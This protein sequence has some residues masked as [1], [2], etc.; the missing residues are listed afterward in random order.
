[1][2][3]ISLLI[4]PASSLCNMRCKYCF[5]EDEAEN[6]DV[7]SHG[8]MSY[9]VM[10]KMLDHIFDYFKADAN[11]NFAFQG[12]EPTCAGLEWFQEF[13][14]YADA[15][16]HANHTLHYAM[17]TN[18]TLLN[19]QWISLLK[20]YEFLVGVSVDGYRENHDSLRHD[21]NTCGTYDRAMSTVSLLKKNEVPFNILT[22]LTE[23]LSKHPEEYW[24]WVTD[25]QFEYIQL[26]PCLPGLNG[27]GEHAL[28]PE[29]FFHFY[30]VLYP[31][32]ESKL[33][34]GHPVSVTLLDNV[35]P[36]FAGIP[37]Q[38]CGYL[39]KCSAQYVIE[40][41]GSCYPCDFYAVDTYKMGN[42]AN[43]ALGTLMNNRVARKFEREPRRKCRECD[44]CGFLHMC[45]RQCKRQNVCYFSKEVCGYKM[46]LEKYSAR[47]QYIASQLW[48]LHE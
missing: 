14:T 1:M 4:K 3:T 15:H 11:I 2:Q 24:N 25:N 21:C 45:G 47:M 32:W 5:Y 6:R 48:G 27:E 37:P 31:L 46:F 39:G 40:A 16:K 20:K 38:Q 9:D 36:M 19:E 30:D 35:I 8:V 18:G 42:I 10:H 34:E 17:Q 13:V 41:D 23:D 26:I 28:K 7:P 22:V 29:S 43:D 44:T 33:Y 12:G